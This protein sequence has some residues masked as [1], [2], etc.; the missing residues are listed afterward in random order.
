[1][2]GPPIPVE[3]TTASDTV[4]HGV[5]LTLVHR[6]AMIALAD[7]DWTK[8]QKSAEDRRWNFMR[9]SSRFWTS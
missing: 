6:S 7:L 2:A 1:M 8:E 4:T 3:R 9:C 5:R